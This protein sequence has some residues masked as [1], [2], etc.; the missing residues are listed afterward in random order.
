MNEGRQSKFR[1]ITRCTQV[2]HGL[3]ALSPSQS[4]CTALPS[5]VSGEQH[6]PPSDLGNQAPQAHEMLEMPI[7][8]S[9]KIMGVSEIC[10]KGQVLP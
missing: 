4:F 7:T 6:S 5:S 2:Q 1:N 3:T 9:V 8:G 10:K